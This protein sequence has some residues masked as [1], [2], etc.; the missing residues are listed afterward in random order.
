MVNGESLTLTIAFLAGLATFLAPCVLPLVPAYVGYLGGQYARVAVA[1][2]SSKQPRRAI[3]LHAL[4]FIAGF[5]LVFLIFHIIAAAIGLWLGSVREVLARVGGLIVIVFG[6][7]TTGVWRIPWLDYDL[8]IHTAPRSDRGYLSS[9][10]M[11][12]VFSAGWSPCVGPTLGLILTLAMYT[13]SVLRAIGLGIAFSL[14]L[15]VPFLLT[16]LGLGWV[17]RLLRRYRR[18]LRGVEIATG[19]LLIVVGLMLVSGTFN[20][21]TN[22]LPPTLIFDPLAKDL[23]NQP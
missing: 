22:L 8:R 12:V 3:V 13:S 20:T 18:F 7:H 1:E 4:A 23:A 2:E 6:L 17:T 11:G 16:A 19:V 5:T 10:L 15:A 9:A 14:G 21:L